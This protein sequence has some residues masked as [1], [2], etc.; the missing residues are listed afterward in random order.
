MFQCPSNAPWTLCL[1]PMTN[2]AEANLCSQVVSLSPSLQGSFLLLLTNI[3]FGK[4]RRAPTP[5]IRS[6]WIKEQVYA[7]ETLGVVQGLAGWVMWFLFPGPTYQLPEEI[8][9]I[10]PWVQYTQHHSWPEPLPCIPC[11]GGPCP[12][13]RWVRVFRSDGTCS[14]R[15]HSVPPDHSPRPWNSCPNTQGPFSGPA[16]GLFPRLIPD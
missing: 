7:A 15:V 6:V 10:T 12:D 11:C 8:A 2:L 5:T 1:E 16:W 9:L 14:P 13:P 3:S 4:F